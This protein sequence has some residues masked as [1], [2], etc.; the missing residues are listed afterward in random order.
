METIEEV[1]TSHISVTGVKYKIYAARKVMF[2]N[3]IYIH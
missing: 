3:N 1:A 2:Q